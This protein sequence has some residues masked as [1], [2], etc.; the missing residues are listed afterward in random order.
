MAEK[1][2]HRKRF[3]SVMNF[4]EA[5]L[6]AKLTGSRK[7]AFPCASNKLPISRLKKYTAI[8]HTGSVFV[9]STGHASNKQWLAFFVGGNSRFVSYNC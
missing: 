1:Q 6:Y 2:K 3:S 8:M 7:M 4:M 9:N 5:S